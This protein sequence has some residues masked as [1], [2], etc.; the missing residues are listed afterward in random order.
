ML[1][2]KHE[3]PPQLISA[4]FPKIDRSH[5][6]RISASLAKLTLSRC[7]FAHH[8]GEWDGDPERTQCYGQQAERLD[9][10]HSSSRIVLRAG[11]VFVRDLFSLPRTISNR[12]LIAIDSAERRLTLLDGEAIVR[13]SYGAVA[14]S[15]YLKASEKEVRL[16]YIRDERSL[17]LGIYPPIELSDN[18]KEAKQ[19]VLRKQREATDILIGIR[20]VLQKALA[21]VIAS[22]TPD[23]QLIKEE[24]IKDLKSLFKLT[25]KNS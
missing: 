12:I 13:G 10:A 21:P 24:L 14:T 16:N 25:K 19:E 2:L 6:I 5:A 7:T 23:L 1:Q 20:D 3:Q 9:C 17:E 22:S 18:K 8:F 4:I 15:S 11:F